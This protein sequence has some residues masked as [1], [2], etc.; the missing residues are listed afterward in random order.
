M[1]TADNFSPIFI[2]K[3][4][5]SDSRTQLKNDLINSPVTVDRLKTVINKL[6]S[7]PPPTP[8]LLA[9]EETPE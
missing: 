4:K 8:G 7:I 2:D 5:K 6:Q 1:V 9:D 3:F